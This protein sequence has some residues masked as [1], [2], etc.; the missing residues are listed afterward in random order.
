MKKIIMGIIIV[1]IAFSM[2]SAVEAKTNTYNLLKTNAYSYPDG[3]LYFS[4]GKNTF[5]GSEFVQFDKKSLFTKKPKVKKVEIDFF[6]GHKKIKK[7]TV[8]YAQL[9]YTKNG[10]A[11]KGKIKTITKKGKVDYSRDKK[12]ENFV[13]FNFKNNN[14]PIKIKV[15]T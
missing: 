15:I 10:K 6:A 9:K 8:Y 11:Y 14:I 5:G 12:G 7:A 3:S 2:L 4:F 13:N 1:L